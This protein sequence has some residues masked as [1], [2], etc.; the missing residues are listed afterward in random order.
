MSIDQQ[1]L[2]AE[3]G[4]QL[5]KAKKLAHQNELQQVELSHA[6]SEL[7]KLQQQVVALESQLVQK[8]QDAH[9]LQQKIEAYFVQAKIAEREQKRLKTRMAAMNAQV[10]SASASIGNPPQTSGQSFDSERTLAILS[11]LLR[12]V[13][14]KLSRLL[15]KVGLRSAKQAKRNAGASV[16]AENVQ[17]LKQSEWFDADFY[18]SNNKDVAEKGIDPVEH[19]LRYGG[20]E[21][22]NPSTKFDSSWYLNQYPD[23]A[24]ANVN[25]LLHFVLYGLQEGRS[26]KRS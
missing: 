24:A 15:T 18:L 10:T 6:K 12:R 21:G 11:R 9:V 26:P 3:F 8:S 17:A 14:A 19:Y 1:V 5:I 25:P 23:V 4:Q 2:E 13:K 22:R 7:T 16:M 20:F